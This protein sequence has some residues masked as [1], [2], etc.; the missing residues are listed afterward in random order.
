MARTIELEIPGRENAIAVAVS[1]P[2]LFSW[3]PIRLSGV[4]GLSWSM[5]GEDDRSGRPLA[6]N[7]LSES[8]SDIRPAMEIFAF[9]DDVDIAGGGNQYM[10]L[11]PWA[12]GLCLAVMMLEWWVYHRR[13]YI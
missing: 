9:E 3:G 8:E 10:P 11:W 13:A 6:V 2:T 4:Y 1:E 12:V 5:P 7:A